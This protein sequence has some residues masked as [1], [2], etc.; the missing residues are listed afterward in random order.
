VMIMADENK[1]ET[2]DGKIF[3]QRLDE[4]AKRCRTYLEKFGTDL[5]A[6]DARGKALKNYDKHIK[7]NAMDAVYREEELRYREAL[8]K[9]MHEK[10]DAELEPKKKELE[11]K[12]EDLGRREA[13]VKLKEQDCKELETKYKDAEAKQA[14]A[15]EQLAKSKDILD[16]VE[17]RQAEVERRKEALNRRE[18]KIAE[19]E[20]HDQK[21]EAEEKSYVPD[22]KAPTNGGAKSIGGPI[23][24]K[25]AAPKVKMGDDLD[26]LLKGL[27]SEKTEKKTE[28]AEKRAE[29]DGPY[30]EKIMLNAGEETSYRTLLKDSGFA[31]GTDKDWTIRETGFGI[32][33]LFAYK[34]EVAKLVEDQ[35]KKAAAAREPK[36]AEPAKAP[37]K[38][39]LIRVDLGFYRSKETIL[40]PYLKEMEYS[41]STDMVHG[42][43]LL[44]IP[45]S[46]YD[47]VVKEANLK[48]ATPK[49]K[50]AKRPVRKDKGQ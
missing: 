13:Y 37:V 31:E 41:S 19:K 26:D 34:P 6:Y 11:E 29:P 33:S 25:H 49:K 44:A 42:K 35:R 8:L 47:S 1:W 45:E 43:A 15:Q 5:K 38:K 12:E 14:K 23:T 20:T 17:R 9:K 27:K 21:S 10:V 2:E 48:L 18:Q 50:F 28:T 36:P 46:E 39:K 4:I 7:K 30:S 16:E 40:K 32:K 24:P 22:A 3:E